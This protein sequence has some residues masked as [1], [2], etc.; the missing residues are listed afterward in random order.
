MK[1]GTLRSPCPY[2]APARHA[3]QLKARFADLGGKV[4]PL[5]PAEYGKR[6][7]EET[8]KWA[9]VIKFA[10]IKPG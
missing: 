10:G 1:M 5:S 7:A 4:L 9:R 3:L 8:E 6:I 2:D